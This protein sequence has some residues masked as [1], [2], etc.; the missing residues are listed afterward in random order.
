MIKE[1]IIKGLLKN[2]ARDLINLEKIN[3]QTY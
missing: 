2:E 3:D 1:K